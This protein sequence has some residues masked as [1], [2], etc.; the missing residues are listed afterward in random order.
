MLILVGLGIFSELDISVR[1]LEEL[2]NCRVAFAERYTHFGSE[3]TIENLEK[4]AGKKIT[5]LTRED[6]EGEEKFLSEA[7]GKR[8]CLLVGGDP[9]ISTTHIS[10][11]LAAKK[12]GIETKIIH[13]SSIFTAAV[14]ESGLQIYKFGKTVTLPF[15][16]EN[17]KPTSTYE[18]IQEN[19]SRGLHTLVFLDI[20]EKMMEA[21]EALELL[22]KMEKT[23]KGKIARAGDSVVVL[24]KIGGESQKIFFGKISELLK[25]SLG[26]P[27]FIL[28]F[29]GKLHFLEEEA[30]ERFR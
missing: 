24:S 25:R 14:G 9:M 20:A 29:P 4:L 21:K 16:R 23:K 5:I 22:A 11:V 7:K 19:A 13:S 27:P 28:I 2:K 10:L 12:M 8:V 1:G 17:Y 15:W 26:A 30:L 3:K 18:V 6:V